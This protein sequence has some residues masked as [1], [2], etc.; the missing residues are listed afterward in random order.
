MKKPFTLIQYASF[1]FSLLDRIPDLLVGGE[2]RRGRHRTGQ[3]Q[4]V[5]L[6]EGRKHP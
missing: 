4:D 3:A 5:D 2:P 6:A 1:D